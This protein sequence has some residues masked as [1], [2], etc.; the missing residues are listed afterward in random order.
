MTLWHC[1]SRQI[2]MGGTMD[3]PEGGN[4]MES[5]LYM[6]NRLIYV[7]LFAFFPGMAY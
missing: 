6:Y 5:I 1:I 3:L 2:D 7:F 4:L